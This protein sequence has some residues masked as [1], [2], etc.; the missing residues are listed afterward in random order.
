MK[1]QR[2]SFVLKLM[3]IKYTDSFGIW[4]QNLNQ[5]QQLVWNRNKFSLRK[6]PIQKEDVCTQ[7]PSP[8]SLGYKYLISSTIEFVG[9]DYFGWLRRVDLW[10]SRVK[11]CWIV[12]WVDVWFV[13]LGVLYLFVGCIV[14]SLDFWFWY[15]NLHIAIILCLFALN[16]VKRGYS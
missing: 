9:F 3:D 6:H 8:L 2:T 14:V 11:L 13:G 1:N 5:N 4:D 16:I 12:F 7:N 10:L 15:C